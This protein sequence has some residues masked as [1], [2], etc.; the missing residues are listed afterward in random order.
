MF[1]PDLISYDRKYDDKYLVKKWNISEKV[2]NID[3]R[4]TAS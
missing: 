4:I 1:V 2:G 3:S